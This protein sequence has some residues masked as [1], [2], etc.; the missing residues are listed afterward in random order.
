MRTSR[1]SRRFIL[2]WVLFTLVPLRAFAQASQ[3]TSLS[4]SP[5]TLNQ[6]QCYTMTVG[7]GANMTLD[8]EYTFNGGP[9]QTII[10]WPSLDA[11]GRAYICTSS[12]TATG[13]YTFVAVRNALTTAWVSVSASVT[14]TA[15]PRP[16]FSLSASPASRTV[17][18]GQS[19]SWPVTVSGING[20]TSSVSLSV[21]GV[22]SGASASFS[23]NPVSPGGSATLTVSTTST[24][25]TGSFT[26]TVTGTGGGLTRSASV[27]LVINP[28]QSTSL[29]FNVSQGYAGNDCYFITVGNGAGMMIDLQYTLNGVAQPVW[30][31]TLDANG[32]WRYCLNHSDMLGTYTFTAM[33]NRL[34]SDWVALSPAVTFRVRPPQP[35]SLSVSP[36]AV[37]AGQGSYRMTVGNGAGVTLDVQY[38]INGGSVQTMSGWSS[39]VAVSPESPNGQA[40]IW[41]GLCAKPGNYVF[42]A[43]KNTLNT[44]WVTVSA[45][46]TINPPAGPVVTS[47][48]PN[49]GAADAGV[50][51]T[52]SGTNL[53]GVTLSTGWSGLTFSNVSNNGAG[54]AATATFNI[55]SSAPAGVATVTL[56]AAGGSTTF[57]FAVAASPVTLRKEYIYVGGKLVATEVP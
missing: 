32:Q 34:R 56:S 48:S 14:V 42:T 7:N 47:V 33:K 11:N 2:G 40:D 45:S 41:P 38:T 16:D 54:N 21:S 39:L 8:L 57:S 50:E 35:A 13:T 49:S 17:N 26:L 23:A 27:A 20:F 44:A 36:A 15:P 3:P 52:V 46:V 4:I 28:R 43:V 24:A 53:C 37:T 22:P 12:A 10:D 19:T 5:S 31:T 51:V 1:R 25:S 29:S 30:S 9:V 18:Q 6:G 55:A